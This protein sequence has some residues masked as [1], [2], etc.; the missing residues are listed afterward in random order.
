MGPVG[1][2]KSV[3]CVNEIRDRI[4]LQAPDDRGVRRTRFGIFR[5]TYGELRTTTIKTWLDWIPDDLC[6]LVYDSPIRGELRCK[7]PD[8]TTV[9]G[10][11]YFASLDREKD[12]RKVLSF[13]LTGAWI[14]EAREFLWRNFDAIRRRIGRYPNKETSPF[15]W[16]GLL[17]DTNPCDDTHWWY[18]LAEEFEVDGVPKEEIEKLESFEFFRQPP[19]L[20][21]KPGVKQLTGNPADY[22]PNPAAENVEH[23][24]LGYQYWFDQ[25]LGAR[26]QDTKVYVMGEYGSVQS[27]MPV[28]KDSF[29]DSFHVSQ[30]SLVPIKSKP[31]MLAWDYGMNPALA[32]AQR[33][34]R[35]QIRILRELCG[36]GI[37]LEQFVE[38]MVLPLL[39]GEF[40]ENQI[41]LSVGDPSGKDP[42]DLDGRSALQA[43]EQAGI[44]TIP[45]FDLSNKI[46]PRLAA[47]R[48]FLS[49]NI[50]GEPALLID[51]S[52]KTLRK[53]FNSGYCF[54]ALQ[55]PGEPR[56]AETPDKNRYSHIHDAV[57]YLLMEL[58]RR[59]DLKPKNIIDHGGRGPVDRVANY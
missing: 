7:L 58:R 23:Q 45:C 5:N 52:C 26:P 8:G 43:L 33:T 42:R 47:V 30:V 28:Y 3:G 35:G 20:L 46:E 37:P 19:A 17:M 11:V 14:N 53:G 29:N 18:Q 9:L 57:Q 4:F 56:H 15:T 34:V 48:W 27:G 32:V 54:R 38:E 39:A 2:G 12:A 36:V 22:I 59:M 21:L 1:S 55:I 50:G 24:Q 44:K 49:R 6:P 10:E 51:P 40:H 31:I 25:I 16:R 41:E 13:E